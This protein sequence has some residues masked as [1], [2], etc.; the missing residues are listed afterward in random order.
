MGN[1]DVWYAHADI[2]RGVSEFRSGVKRQ[3]A[4]RTK[5]ALAKARTRDSMSA[6]AKLTEVVDGQRRIV[7]PGAADRPGGQLGKPGRRDEIYNELHKLLREY[8]STLEVD[9]RGVLG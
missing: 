4:K 6:F 3:I 7:R 5:K 8:R 2:R 9:R 1:L